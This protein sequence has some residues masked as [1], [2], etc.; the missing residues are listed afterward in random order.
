MAASWC[1]MP[2]RIPFFPR[3]CEW[4]T[5]RLLRP[6]GVFNRGRPDVTTQGLPRTPLLRVLAD[7]V[8]H[9]AGLGASL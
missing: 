8:P 9:R 6:E 3:H 4:F 5:I 7:F 2:D 1:L